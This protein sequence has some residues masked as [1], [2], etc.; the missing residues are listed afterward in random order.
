[1]RERVTATTLLACLLMAAV[2][3]AADTAPAVPDGDWPLFNRA[4][5]G[6]RYSP[7]NMIDRN[8]IK[9]LRVA[10][11]HQPG[12]ITNGLHLTPLAIDGVVYYS[13]PWNE[14]FAVDGGTGRTIWRFR[15]ELDP[16]V[17]ELA[18][19]GVSRGVSVAGGRVYLGTLDGRIMALDQRTG[20]L[21]WER[22]VTQPRECHCS[23]TSPPQ[24]AGDVVIAGPNGGDV[25][26]R[27]R[28]YAFDAATGEPR[29]EFETLSK[30][31]KSW[32][33]DSAKFG[34]GS[35]WMPG[36]WDPQSGLY[37]IGT[38]NAAPDFFGGD[39][40]GDNKYTASLLALEAK[41]GRLVWHFQEVPN[42]LYDYDSAYEVLTIERDGRSLLV[43]LN[44]NGFVYVYEKLT[45]KLVNVWPLAENYN[46]AS[47]IDPKT[48]EMSDR[49]VTK[50]G[51]EAVLCPAAV[52][53]RSWNPGA[54]NPQTGLWYTSAMEICNRVKPVREKPEELGLPQLY[55]GSEGVEM[56][57]PPGKPASVR[58]DARDPVTGERRWSVP[59]ELPI[60][61]AALT[62]AGGLVFNTGYDGV[63]HAYDADDGRELWQF[64]MG[65]GSRGSVISYTAGG[66]QY[67]LATSGVSG[68]IPGMMAAVFPKMRD[69]PGGGI[70]VAFT[71]D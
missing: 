15:P 23:F 20:K 54:Y 25:P 69:V 67:I 32:P 36:T 3:A 49:L 60:L 57:P 24:P 70:L 9:R 39:R 30:D 14:V 66:R 53:T 44:K 19:T 11:I 5:D 68:F 26:S 13:G 45:G 21:L 47:R 12:D 28:I 29:W 4:P 31:P 64:P 59:Y 52:G 50:A 58:L 41:T 35:A 7:L 56:I 62:T 17:E 33:G 71:I 37:F 1:M 16:V 43:H 10:W 46:F 6:W 34:G 42:D 63:L 51:E 18:L 8:T 55:F 2:A 61:G 65:S 48:G 27:G 22:Q 40:D 38:S